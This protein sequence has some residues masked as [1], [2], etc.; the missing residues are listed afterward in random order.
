MIRLD[1]VSKR[2]GQQVLFVDGSFVDAQMQGK[3]ASTALALLALCED[4]GQLRR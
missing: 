2:F 4:L 3:A 1:S